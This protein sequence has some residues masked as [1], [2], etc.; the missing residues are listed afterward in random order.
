MDFTEVQA[1]NCRLTRWGF[2]VYVASTMSNDRLD[3][4][5]ARIKDDSSK[6]APTPRA[7]SK[8]KNNRNNN[9]ILKKGKTVVAETVAATVAATVDSASGGGGRSI[10]PVL[11]NP[12]P[13]VREEVRDSEELDAWREWARSRQ[14]IACISIGGANLERIGSVVSAR[15]RAAFEAGFK[16]GREDNG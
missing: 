10:T 12:V 15:V 5:L 1:K 8:N 3:T 16:A 9:A 13:V 14:G 7:S 2:V 6:P 11:V 4:I